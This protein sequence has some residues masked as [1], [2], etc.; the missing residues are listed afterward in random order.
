MEHSPA[1]RFG[2]SPVRKPG[3]LRHAIPPDAED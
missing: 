1:E 2:A 3:E